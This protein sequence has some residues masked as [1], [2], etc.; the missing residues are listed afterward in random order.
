MANRPTYRITFQDDNRGAN[1]PEI[2]RLRIVL[3]RLLRTFG[4]RALK[5][6][7]LNEPVPHAEDAEASSPGPECEVSP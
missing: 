6:E 2:I 4:F 3:K 7:E 1:S 5:V